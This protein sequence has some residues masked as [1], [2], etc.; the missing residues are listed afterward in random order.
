MV[1]I[2]SRILFTIVG[3]RRADLLHSTSMSKQL[4]NHDR[5]FTFHEVR[6]KESQGPSS[7]ICSTQRLVSSAVLLCVYMLLAQA[8]KPI[9]ITDLF[10]F[11]GNLMSKYVF[12]MIVSTVKTITICNKPMN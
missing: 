8:N 1:N 6:L 5:P 2:Y 12:Q 11:H 10:S 7:L 4:Q 3:R 9:A